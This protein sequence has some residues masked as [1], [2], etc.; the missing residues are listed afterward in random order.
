MRELKGEVQLNGRGKPLVSHEVIVSLIQATRTR[1]GL[2]VRAALDQRHYPKGIKVTK[3]EMA[4]LALHPEAFHG[5]WNYTL[6]PRFGSSPS[7]ENRT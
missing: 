4:D 5:E 6:R 7:K 3:A 1:K 2:K